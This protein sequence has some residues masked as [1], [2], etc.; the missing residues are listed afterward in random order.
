MKETEIERER[1]RVRERADFSSFANKFIH[2]HLSQISVC[3]AAR[4][5]PHISLLIDIILYSS[6]CPEILAFYYYYYLEA[7]FGQ[8]NTLRIRNIAFIR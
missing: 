3:L 5:M 4:A 2:F 1:G 7:A 6:S 8:P